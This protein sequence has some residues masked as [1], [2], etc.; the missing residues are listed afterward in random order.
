MIVAAGTRAIFDASCRA[1]AVQQFYSI[2]LPEYQPK[3]Y[4]VELLAC[5]AADSGNVS[6]MTKLWENASP[7]S[8]FAEQTISLD[9]SGYTHIVVLSITSNAAKASGNYQPIIYV[10]NLV[11]ASGAISS[12][13]YDGSALWFHARTV[14]IVSGGVKFGTGYMQGL[15]NGINHY[16]NRDDRAVPVIIYGVRGLTT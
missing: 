15:S 12:C 10:P 11:G 9:L 16:P 4:A 14:S 7:T 1:V 3:G 13:G 6:G 5:N 2:P 8:E